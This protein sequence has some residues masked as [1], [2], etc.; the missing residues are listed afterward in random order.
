[1]KTE[2]LKNKMEESM[3]KV[4]DLAEDAY[5]LGLESMDSLN[6][7][8]EDAKGD[9]VSAKEA[10]KLS[11]EEGKEKINKVLL[12]AQMNFEE[13]KKKHEE[14]KIENDKIKMEHSYAKKIKY[15][16]SIARFALVALEEAR[17]AYLEAAQFRHKYEEQYGKMEDVM[18]KDKK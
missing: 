9:L 8:T 4:K 12:E 18:K 10:F 3:K 14:E 7:M 6:K 16:D 13:L 1:M 15:A 2:E 5:L 11:S 17:V